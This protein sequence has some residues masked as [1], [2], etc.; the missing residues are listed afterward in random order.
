[1]LFD[2][3]GLGHFRRPRRQPVAHP[4]HTGSSVG[5]LR[6]D[7]FRDL[8]DQARGDLQK[9]DRQLNHYPLV[10][11]ARCGPSLLLTQ[12][13]ERPKQTFE[14]SAENGSGEPEL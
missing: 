8:Q 10:D 3:A 13:A 5:L 4:A 6:C 2:V 11:R 9:V 7:G 1:M 14:Q 12:L